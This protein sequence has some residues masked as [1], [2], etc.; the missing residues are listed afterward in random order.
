M[1]N[2]I[3]QSTIAILF[4]FLIIGFG[5]SSVKMMPPQ[6][7]VYIDKR[8]DKYVSPPCLRK[9]YV[10]NYDDSKPDDFYS[11]TVADMRM[12]Q[13]AGE[14]LKA[15]RSC[16]EEAKG[17]Y[18]RQSLIMSKIFPKERWDKNGEWLW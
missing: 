10:E 6:A 1:S 9:G 16:M 7:I 13:K 5:V 14:N 4:L 8:H 12:R 3:L 15:D 17:F 18:V 2:R 11:I